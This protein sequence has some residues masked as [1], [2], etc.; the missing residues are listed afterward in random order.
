MVDVP[1][2]DMTGG[3]IWPIQGKDQSYNVTPSEV[4]KRLDILNGAMVKV[5]NANLTYRPSTNPAR[6]AWA[7]T[8]WETGAGRK[9]NWGA[10]AEA[11]RQ[12]D[13]DNLGR[14]LAALQAEVGGAQT[15]YQGQ[16][17][18][19]DKNKDWELKDVE[20]Q[21]RLLSA[22]NKGSSGAM[23]I[24]SAATTAKDLKDLGYSDEEIAGI[25]GLPA[26]KIPQDGADDKDPATWLGAQDPLPAYGPMQQKNVNTTLEDLRY[27]GETERSLREMA[28]LATQFDARI[29][30]EMRAKIGGIND[31]FAALAGIEGGAEAANKI[32]QFMTQITENTL[33]R[34]QENKMTPVSNA[35]IET[36]Q[37]SIM[38]PTLDP[39][40]KKRRIDQLL[41]K[42]ALKRTGFV[43]TLRHVYKYPRQD[44]AAELDPIFEFGETG[45]L[46]NSP[47]LK[48]TRQP[49]SATMDFSNDPDFQSLVDHFQGKSDEADQETIENEFGPGSYDAFVE[50]TGG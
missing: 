16:S 1:D 22:R 44:I 4:Q 43:N 21:I 28:D 32:K 38:D 40:G 26:H 15:M 33:S 24:K 17:D 3:L 39:A 9:P 37:R 5:R 29:A 6:A 25:T 10:V 34:L 13:Q 8:I 11:G 12:Q 23:G 27:T 35:D 47:Y 7:D 50:Q 42:I 46:K 30:P 49:S 2:D 45:A 19:L 41:N 14:Q 20:N 31:W 36:L 48:E 18:M